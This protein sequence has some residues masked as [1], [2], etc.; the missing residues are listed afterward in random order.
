ML[1]RHERSAK[2]LM[3]AYEYRKGLLSYDK[4]APWQMDNA[5]ILSAYR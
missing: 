1:S 4:I 3:S 2:S 5:F